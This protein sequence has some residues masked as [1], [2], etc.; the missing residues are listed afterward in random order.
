MLLGRLL[1]FGGEVV[2]LLV[3]FADFGEFAVGVGGLT[4]GLVEAAEA[5]MGVGLGGVEFY[6]ALEGG[7]SFWMAF[8]L[9][10]DGTQVD[11]GDAKIISL[12]RGPFE[13][14][15]GLVEVVFFHGDIP[16]IGEGLG[17]VGV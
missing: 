1:H 15:K 6:G 17:V 3:E 13:V 2:G 7:E 14:E 5:E 9:H 4:H 16:E 8:L 10:Q 11:V 12:L